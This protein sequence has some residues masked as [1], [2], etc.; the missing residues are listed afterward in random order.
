M[1]T[2]NDIPER[3]YIIKRGKV[4]ERFTP[5]FFHKQQYLA[6]YRN[7]YHLLVNDADPYKVIEELL[8]INEKQ[9]NELIKLN[10]KNN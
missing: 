2:I 9:N 6:L 7:I 10:N 8:D 3:D 4:L 5:E 1:I